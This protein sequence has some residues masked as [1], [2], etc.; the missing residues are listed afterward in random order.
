MDF[1]AT[2]VDKEMKHNLNQLSEVDKLLAENE[3]QINELVKQQLS[4]STERH[5]QVRKSK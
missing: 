4:T 5:K 3:K 1:F 2:D